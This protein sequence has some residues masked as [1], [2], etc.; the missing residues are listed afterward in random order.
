MNSKKLHWFFV[1]ASLLMVAIFST[2]CN[3]ELSKRDKKTPFLFDISQIP[4]SYA[5]SNLAL[6]NHQKTNGL[7]I[8]DV[9][10]STFGDGILFNLNLIPN[11]KKGRQ[12]TSAFG[13][14]EQ[15]FIFNKNKQIAR[16]CFSSDQTM[17]LRIF[18]SELVLQANEHLSIHILDPKTIR[19]E[20]SFTFGES[21]YIDVHQDFKS[22][23][24][25]YI[26]KVNSGG[27]QNK[28]DQLT[29]LLNQKGFVELAIQSLHSS[30]TSF[31]P[32][33]S[34]DESVKRTESA[35]KRWLEKMPP[36]PIEFEQTKV[37][38]A[39][40]LWSCLLKPKGHLK[41]PGILMSKNIM[42]YVWSW[43]NCFNA[44]ACAEG[45]P[46]LAYDQIMLMFDQQI[47]STGK[48]PDL[49]S[50]GR[51]IANHV[52]P[53]VHGWALEK[54]ILAGKLN[55]SQLKES[56][57]RLAKWT[58][59]WIIHRDSNGNGLPE[60]RHGNDSGWD[61]G[62]EFDL[63]GKTHKLG[64]R[65]SPNLYAYLILQMDVLSKIAV[66][67]GKNEAALSW[68]NK[69][70]ELLQL[71]LKHT[72]NGDRFI[73]TLLEDGKSVPQ[74]ES[75]MAFLPLI[76]GKKLP[77][78]IREKLIKDLKTEGY[79]T[80][81]GLA[82]EN[83]NSIHYQSDGYWR[84]PIWAPSTMIIVEGLY[85]SGEQ[86]LAREIALKFAKL[87]QANGFAENFD[88]LTGQGFRDL[89]HTWTASVFLVLNSKYLT[90]KNAAHE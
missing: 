11:L 90:P 82:T 83:P 86:E 87:C 51:M 68:Q 41:R 75:L 22:G 25:Y 38:A 77:A 5:G 18:T 72:W 63:Q 71:M 32:S 33:Y 57:H 55:E 45:L 12:I 76:L 7:A 54:L 29:F 23:K 58:D 65:E 20:R 34:F 49:L 85:R 21:K 61:N 52:K 30:E 70:D 14:P 40:L 60:Y 74:S 81:F 69:S 27:I 46:D 15:A 80:K 36:A 62:T 28:G 26:L 2:T 53:P 42:T 19:L 17:R 73:T 10:N 56:Y 79:I 3:S 50:W 4:F 89:A 44:L 67:L 84:G 43:D 13:N 16:A 47:D 9:A 48:I 39:Y 35:F 6:A 24:A 66:E 37:K 8:V 78:H 31:T 88:A 1:S 64:W 59:F